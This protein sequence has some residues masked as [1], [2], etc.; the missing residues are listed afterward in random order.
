M[1]VA[2][3]S[4]SETLLIKISPELKIPEYIHKM[5]NKVP[6]LKSCLPLEQF[7]GIQYPFIGKIKYTSWGK[8]PQ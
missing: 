3:D 4:S 5:T 7:H 8:V 2:L 1:N 6:L